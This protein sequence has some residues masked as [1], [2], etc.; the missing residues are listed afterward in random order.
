MNTKPDEHT[1]TALRLLNAGLEQRIAEKTEA[2]EQ[3]RRE[4][5]SFSHSISHDLRAPL[6]TIKGFSRIVLE[7]STES[8]SAETT[9][10]LGRIVAAAERMDLLINGLLSLSQ[11]SR[12]ELRRR[13]TNL[14]ELA[15]ETAR[16]LAQ[17]QPERRV[18]MLIAP[19]IM[20]DTDR[21]MAQVVLETLVGNAWKF[22]SRTDAVKIEFGQFE[23]KGESVFFVRD[24]GAGFDMRY[25][26]KLFGPFQRMHGSREFEGIGIG[27][28]IAQRIVLRHGG[29]IWAEAA[30]EEGA[31]F[32]FSLSPAPRTG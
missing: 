32:F 17:A 15:G 12:K 3:A 10:N 25:A 22:T 21:D 19:E 1:E 5:D 18:E 6:R 2:L 28:S 9:E 7:E 29:R 13:V 23:R 14:S 26:G 24:N 11:I 27:L 31:T 4:L 30:A 16:R 8:H 20:A